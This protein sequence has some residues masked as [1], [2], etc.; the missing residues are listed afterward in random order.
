[1]QIVIIILVV[2]SIWLI[3]TG[4]ERFLTFSAARN[5]SREFES[6]V[7]S[8]LENHQIDEAISLSSKYKK[9]HLA[10]VINAG[11]QEFR[12]HQ[13]SED[14]IDASKRSLQRATSIKVSEFKRGLTGLATIGSTAPL[15]GLC[16]SVFGIINV[17]DGMRAA[18]SAGIAAVSGGIAEALVSTVVGLGVGVPA[19][20]LSK[21]FIS[22]V[23]NFVVEMD[24]SSA[25]LINLFLKHH[26]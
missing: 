5:Q 19:V 1:M 9:S 16:G 12:A 3:I 4:I 6:K 18:E 14:V 21:Y 8:T 24:K 20:W 26:K 17:F 22:K 15:V 7:A 13:D 2:M 23:E 10:M 25:E 11:L